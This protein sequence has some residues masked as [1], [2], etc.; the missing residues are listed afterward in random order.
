[1]LPIGEQFLVEDADG[2]H[3]LTFDRE[4]LELTA[5]PALSDVCHLQRS[6]LFPSDSESAWV[7]AERPCGSARPSALRLDKSTFEITEAME[8]PFEADAR[9]TRAFR[10]AV[11]AGKQRGLWF[12]KAK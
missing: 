2:L 12:S 8:L 11:P 1:M 10:Y 4:R 3:R 9:Y 6:S 7:V 5:E